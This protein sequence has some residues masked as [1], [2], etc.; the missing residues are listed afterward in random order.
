MLE[1]QGEIQE[2]WVGKPLDPFQV[3]LTDE[4]GHGVPHVPVEFK[5]AEGSGEFTYV[6]ER[7]DL[8]GSAIAEFVPSDDGRYRVECFIGD[9]MV[10][11]KGIVAPDRRRHTVPA[12]PAQEPAPAPVAAAPAATEAPKR[13]TPKRKPRARRASAKERPA[14]PPAAPPPAPPAAPPIV[15]V[16]APRLPQPPAPVA[17]PAPVVAAP[18]RVALPQAQPK[19]VRRQPSRPRPRVAS[20][21][22]A[23]VIALIAIVVLLAPLAAVL[24]YQTVSAPRA[25]VECSGSW[26]VVG[27]SL[28]FQDCTATNR[29]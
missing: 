20:Q 28:V 8:S 12:P 21:P 22:L 7:T 16:I 24:V 5:V 17:A 19:A 29:R 14:Q 15:V 11:F 2:G 23:L 27:D 18:S 1:F 13:E 9:E 10:P 3:K 4:E 6:D 26:R 25:V